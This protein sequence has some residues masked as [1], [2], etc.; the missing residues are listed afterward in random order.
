MKVLVFGAG[1]IGSLVGAR[2]SA[3]HDITLVARPAAVEAVSRGGLRFE[4]HTQ[5]TF[6]PHAVSSLR[7]A[8]RDADWTFITVKA[9]DTAT[10]CRELREHLISGNVV[11]LQNGLGNLEQVE[12]AFG[13]RRAFAASTSHGVMAVGPAHW[14][15]AGAGDLVVG[16]AHPGGKTAAEAL[17]SSFTEA[18]MPCRVSAEIRGELWGKAIVNAGINPVAALARVANGRL[19][20]D[21]K[22]RAEMEATAREAWEVA[23]AVGVRLP[24]GDWIEKTREV[25]RRT[26]ANRNSMVQ[27]VEAGKRTEIDSITGVVV[28]EGQR[29]GVPVAVNRKL[30]EQVRALAPKPSSR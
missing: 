10:A 30:L 28:R 4:G 13:P 23:K 26:A 25:A 19:L 16:A 20:E 14:D 8:P 6:R 2:L 18:G 21:P 29:L 3:H 15:H 22:L 1:A 24:P 17:A 9:F 12:E 7:D 11:T 5:G 27:S